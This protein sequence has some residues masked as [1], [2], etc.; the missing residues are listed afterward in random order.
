[1]TESGRRP[2]GVVGLGEMGLPIAA[3][4]ARAGFDVFAHDTDSR[5]RD[6]AAASG[7]RVEP[8]LRV[9]AGESPTWLVVVPGDAVPAVV[10]VLGDALPAS[11]VVIVCS[12]VDPPL[13]TDVNRVLKSRGI[14]LCEAALAR[15]VPAAH[16]ASLLLYCGGSVETLQQVTPVLA[17]IASDVVHVGQL[18]S[19]Q[20]AKLLNN[21]LLWSN[22]AAVTETMR[23]AAAMGLDTDAIADALARGSG[24]SWVLDT[25]NRPRPMPDVEHDLAR[26]LRLADERSVELPLVRAVEA[27]MREVR[28]RKAAWLDGAGVERSMAE[29]VRENLTPAR[30]FDAEEV[31]W[32]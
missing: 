11:A 27:V 17:A 2:V 22:V 8:D 6:R 29:F 31:R 7:I 10:G 23:L 12:S 14:E 19:G 1:M 26:V 5:A 20:T 28:T 3:N 13:M 16:D 21:L 24:R 18:G 25:W 9:A 15:G 30:A 32:S 4:L